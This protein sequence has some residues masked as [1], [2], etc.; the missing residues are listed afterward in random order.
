MGPFPPFICSHVPIFPEK[1]S[2]SCRIVRSRVRT[3]A[4]TA[5]TMASLAKMR[6]VS[7]FPAS[8]GVNG[9]DTLARTALPSRTWRIPPSE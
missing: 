9:R 6:W 8:S 7:P 1:I 3:P 4:P 5:K 2:A